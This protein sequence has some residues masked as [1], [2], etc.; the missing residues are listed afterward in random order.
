V[1]E[2]DDEPIEERELEV[3]QLLPVPTEFRIANRR[4]P[5]RIEK[6]GNCL[7]RL[8]TNAEN[9]YLDNDPDKLRFENETG[10]TRHKSRSKLRNGKISVY[11][12]CPKTTRVGQRDLITFEL[13]LPDKTCLRAQ[14][15]VACIE[16]FERK[17]TKGQTNIPEPKLQAVR[18][19]D[20]LWKTLEYDEKSIGEI[21]LDNT[22]EENSMI[23]VSLENKNLA[24][25]LASRSLEAP[26]AAGVEDRYAAG[27]GYYLLLEEVDRRTHTK[28]SDSKRSTGQLDDSEKQPGYS[29][30]LD[31]VS[32]TIAFLSMPP[33]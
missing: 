18:K 23:I 9:S 7:I 28:T 22:N 8:E 24:G 25:T 6:G 30:S 5:I 2:E 11:L 16:P 1:E 27:M 13:E 10:I 14:R 12:H 31:M 32:E 3:P 33:D 26:V 19:T 29:R 4:T 20:D 15:D 21:R 17:K